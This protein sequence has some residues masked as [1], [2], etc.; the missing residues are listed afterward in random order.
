MKIK[1]SLAGGVLVLAVAG[2]AMA[3]ATSMA[4]A[5]TL[6]PTSR[7]STADTTDAPSIGA[8]GQEGDRPPAGVTVEKG[9][10]AKP[11]K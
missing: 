4:T 11:A 1:K 5:S 2:G 8:V 6:V 3:L 7:P 9:Q 10:E